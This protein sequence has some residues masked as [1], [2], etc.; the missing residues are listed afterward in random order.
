MSR[1]KRRYK[2]AMER[3]PV[4]RG[5]SLVELIIVIIVL[6]I[7]AALAIPYFSEA[8]QEAMESALKTN[9]A[10]VRAAID[11]YAR[12]HGDKLPGVKSDSGGGQTDATT[13]P[14]ALVRQLTLYTKGSGQVATTKGNPFSYGPYLSHF[15]ENPLA[16]VTDKAS[17]AVTEDA[18]TL[19]ADASPT[20]AWKYSK[21]TGKIIAN[22]TAYQ[23]W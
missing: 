4:V 16:K 14:V 15:P 19:T 17:V 12:D 1:L 6:G 2:L 23:T 10:A 13:A 9:L 18:G 22:V 3:L 20:T 8:T 11:R 7:L 5:F 21:E